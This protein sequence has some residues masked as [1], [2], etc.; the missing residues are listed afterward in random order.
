[1]D[2]AFVAEQI[3][4]CYQDV[5]AQYRRDDE[6]EITTQNFRHL[7]DNLKKLSSS[8]GHPIDVLDAGCG[9]GRSFHCLQN[10]RRLVG[11][12]LSPD[13]LAAAE[14]PVK[15]KEISAES[16]QLRCGDIH[17]SIFPPASFNL[18]YSLGMFGNGCPVTVELVNNFYDWLAPGGHLFFNVIGM[19]T[20]ARTTRL[21]KKMRKLVYPILPRRLKTVLDER[22]MR[23][24]F[25]GL[26]LKQLDAIMRQTRF[27]DFATSEHICDSPLWQG[28]HLECL[29]VK[30]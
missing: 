1:M 8:F 30:P 13:M 22:E 17:R 10:V 16:I 12:D 24:P 6:I 14:N 15:S 28:V 18:I 26:T 4:T 11:C 21:R 23:M 2:F 20:L 25:F 3:R 29:A 5:S 7:S 19:A 27:P 9:T